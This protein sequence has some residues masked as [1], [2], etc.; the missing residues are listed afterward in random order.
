MLSCHAFLALV[1]HLL[2][3][4]VLLL[5]FGGHLLELHYGFLDGADRVVGAAFLL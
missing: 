4:C 2:D 5:L 1:L 3:Q